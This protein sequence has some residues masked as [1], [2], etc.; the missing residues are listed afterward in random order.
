MTGTN[1]P[2][3]ALGCWYFAWAAALAYADI[4]VEAE[5]R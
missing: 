2:L 4:F 3:A 1:I 5:D